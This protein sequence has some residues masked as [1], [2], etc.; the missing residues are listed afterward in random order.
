MYKI[1]EGETLQQALLKMKIDLGADAVLVEHKMIKKGGLF[2]LFSKNIFIVKA[3]PAAEVNPQKSSNDN[4]DRVDK[5]N[6][7]KKLQKTIVNKTQE[8]EKIEQLRA[9]S[10]HKINHIIDDEVIPEPP[11]VSSSKGNANKNSVYSPYHKSNTNELNNSVS[12]NDIEQEQ[13]SQP[14]K[15]KKDNLNVRTAQSTQSMKKQSKQDEETIFG[16]QDKSRQSGIKNNNK[17]VEESDNFNKGLA[18]EKVEELSE[19]INLLKN[20]LKTISNTIGVVLEKVQQDDIKYPGLLTKYYMYLMENEFEE[21][22][23]DLIIKNVE[24][25]LSSKDLD[26]FSLVDKAIKEE[27]EKILLKKE[28]IKFDDDKIKIFVVVGPT[29]VGKTTTLAKIGAYLS[30]EEHKDIAFLTLDTYRLAAVEQLKK[31][32]QVLNVPMKVIFMPE[33][34]NEGIMNYLNKDIILIDTA[35][36]SPTDKVQMTELQEFVKSSKFTMDIALVISSTTKY[37]D[38]AEIVEK[39]SAI[40]FNQLI[41]TKIDETISLGPVMSLVNKYKMPISYITNGQD[42]P[43]NFEIFNRKKMINLLFDNFKI[44][45]KIEIG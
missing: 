29:G 17:S 21:E 8:L 27:I 41:V 19:E 24:T 12:T 20:E 30:L 18:G 6:N 43:D 10:K 37:S 40:K 23:A 4:F 39:F 22:C 42:V 16:N 7:L 3:T 31:Y 26:N 36:R 34:I 38:L 13:S 5:N 2:G 33:E 35:G 11:P 14:A 32:A 45:E 44:S 9:I 25:R 28:I 15:I 1:Y